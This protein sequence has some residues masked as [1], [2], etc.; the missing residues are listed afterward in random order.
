LYASI[1]KKAGDKCVS[2]SVP[3]GFIRVHSALI[4]DQNSNGGILL[5]SCGGQLVDALSTVKS[6]GAQIQQFCYFGAN[7]GEV[8]PCTISV[9]NSSYFGNKIEM[10]SEGDLTLTNSNFQTIGPRDQQT[11]VS[12]LG[13]VWGGYNCPTVA[14]LPT[15]ANCIPIDQ[16]CLL[17]QECH[18]KNKFFGG[19]ESNFRA[20]AMQLMSFDNACIDIAENITMIALDTDPAGAC[21]N[22]L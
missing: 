8:P 17:C 9:S 21:N 5:K 12:L 15:D 20:W 13:S 19:V 3:G 7:S 10:I 18:N 14:A 4:E 1:D 6:A 16:A 2:P 22:H 11:Y